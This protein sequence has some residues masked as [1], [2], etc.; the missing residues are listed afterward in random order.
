MSYKLHACVQLLCIRL[1]GK[2]THYD[3]GSRVPI[4]LSGPGIAPGTAE[5]DTLVSLNDV[6]VA[7]T[8]CSSANCVFF[9]VFLFFLFFFVSELPSSSVQIKCTC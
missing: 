7:V 2:N 6:Y 5:I 8:I 9:F 3:S 1:A 4:L